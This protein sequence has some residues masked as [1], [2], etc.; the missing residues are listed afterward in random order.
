[1]VNIHGSNYSLTANI[2]FNP[3]RPPLPGG[4]ELAPMRLRGETN[5][6][7]KKSNEEIIEVLSADKFEIHYLKID[8]VDV[9]A[10]ITNTKFRST[11]QAIGRVA[12]TLQ[13]FTS[14]NIKFAEISFVKQGLRTATYRVD[15]DGIT[16]EQISSDSAYKSQK[17]IKAIDL[18]SGAYTSQRKKLTWGLGPYFSHRLF[19]PDLPL[20]ME[21]GLELKS[22]YY[23][24][25]RLRLS[26]ALRKSFLTNLTDNRRRSNSV[27]PRVHSDWPL[28]DFAGQD[29]HIHELTLSYVRIWDPAFTEELT[30]LLEPFYAGFGGEILYKPA[31]SSFGLGWIFTRFGK[32][33]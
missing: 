17:T 4:K 1:M 7:F 16:I 19:N 33:L 32:R 18:N 23:I 28:Y 15:L 26:G 22:A 24:T 29:G 31:Q 27:L 2:T 5:L 13:R 20:S 10:V 14:D 11:A 30:S 21:V 3:G 6:P 25:P 8:D 12:S 9:K